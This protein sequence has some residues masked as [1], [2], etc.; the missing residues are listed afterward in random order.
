M[1]K[2]SRIYKRLNKNEWFE[3]VFVI[4]M[5][6]TVTLGI[7]VGVHS[8]FG[9]TDVSIASNK[10]EEYFYEGKYDE[11]IQEFETL[12]K[13]EEWPIWKVKQA[14]IYSIKGDYDKSNSLLKEAVIVRNKLIQKEPD[15]YLDKDNEFMNEVVY[16]FFINKEYEQA[17]SLGED[18]ILNN[19]KYKPLM[20]TMLAIYMSL[21][22]KDNAK[23]IVEEYKVD[24]NSSYDMSVYANMQMVIG[25]INGALSTL[26]EAFELNKDEINIL[27]VVNQLSNYD[28]EEV[29]NTL[30]ELSEDN[31]YVYNLFLAKVYSMDKDKYIEAIDIVDSLDDS[32]KESLVYNVLK[33]QLAYNIGNKEE[34]T[35]IVNKIVDNKESGYAKYYIEATE[36]LKQGN[37]DK[38]IEYSKKSILENNDYAD[39]YGVLLPE[40]LLAK[41]DTDSIES[42]FRTAILEEPFNI[43]MII[44]IGN[45]YANNLGQ[46]DKATQYYEL[47]SKINPSNAEIYY[48]LG[49]M[50][51]NKEKYDTAIEYFEKALSLDNENS[52][53]FRALGTAYY[54]IGENEKSISNTREAYALNEA[55]ILALNNAGCYYMTVE[56]DVWRGFSNIEAA[57]E[58][59]PTNIDSDTKK[60]ITD[61]Y[62]QAKEVFDKYIEDEN[63]DINIPKLNLF[64]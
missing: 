47:A 48:L 14:E 21:D 31:D 34:A 36:Y 26:K 55:D 32:F 42:Y 24:E 30:T 45:F 50:E 2:L 8:A 57:Y 56:K 43:S 40:I 33:A 11:A 51:V 15:K 5:S 20:R 1:K 39:N 6:L 28:R 23:E 60:K 44:N 46:Y 52:K 27:D 19:E 54:N 62:N 22:E 38:A 61:N 4:G 12:Q 58:E 3:P 7:V 59:M 18:Y 25:N 29:I 49:N 63:I 35:D 9:Q 37:Y 53:Y 13:E 17:V 10:G 64:Y 41:N 16:S